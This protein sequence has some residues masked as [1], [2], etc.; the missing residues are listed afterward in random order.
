MSFGLAGALAVSV[1]TA[2]A[3]FSD[4]FS[5]SQASTSYNGASGFS[6]ASTLLTPYGARVLYADILGNTAPGDARARTA[7]SGG[8]FTF[9]SDNEV[10]GYGLAFY[11]FSTPISLTATPV[12][13]VTILS[14]DL[15]GTLSINE[16]DTSGN[17]VS[18][19]VPLPAMPVSGTPLVLTVP[20]NAVGINYAS[21]NRLE[22]YFGGTKGE[23]LSVDGIVAVAVPEPGSLALLG[24][25]AAAGTGWLIRRR[26]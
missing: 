4:D 15:L 2:Q 12:F 6:S 7:V 9:S 8:A 18:T 26:A 11:S 23:D 16:Y 20:T 17:S 21:L 24:V 5:T 3:A 25:A 13:Q 22:F 14:N 19:T 10:T 1:A